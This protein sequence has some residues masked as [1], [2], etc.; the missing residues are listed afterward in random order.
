L[1]GIAGVFHARPKTGRAFFMEILMEVCEMNYKIGEIA[2]RI[3]ELRQ[4]IGFTQEDLA[5]STG[6][7]L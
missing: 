1:G 4:I 5:D 3:R 6:E 7:S 2:E